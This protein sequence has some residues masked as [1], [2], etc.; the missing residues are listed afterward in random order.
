[1]TS[2]A[3]LGARFLGGLFFLAIGSK[4]GLS[5][6]SQSL[7]GTFV[8]FFSNCSISNLLNNILIVGRALIGCDSNVIRL[9]VNRAFL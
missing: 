3:S 5:M 1:M 2:A 9:G 6:A 8:L 4:D 7:F